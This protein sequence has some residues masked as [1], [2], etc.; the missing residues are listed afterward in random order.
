MSVLIKCAGTSGQVALP[1]KI[2]EGKTM[3]E[4]RYEIVDGFVTVDDDDPAIIAH[5]VNE[6]T[7]M[8]GFS[9]ASASEQEATTSSKRKTSSIKEKSKA[10]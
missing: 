7:S 10:D 9:L 2:V 4:R 8:R 3:P 6:I 5:D 1:H